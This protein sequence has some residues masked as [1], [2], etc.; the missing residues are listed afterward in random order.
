MKKSNNQSLDIISHL[1]KGNSRWI[2]GK[3]KYDF[4]TL[5]ETTKQLIDHQLPQILE[6]LDQKERV[7]KVY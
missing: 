3:S 7:V 1:L 5:K 2:K 4:N 6:L